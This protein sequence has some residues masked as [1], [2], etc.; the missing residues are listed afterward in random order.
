MDARQRVLRTAAAVTAALLSAGAVTCAG[1]RDLGP[2]AGQPGVKEFL[3]RVDEYIAVRNRAAKGIAPLTETDS[4]EKIAARE[5]AVAK[6]VITE[7]VG[8]QE[9]DIFAPARPFIL[10][11]VRDDWRRRSREERAGLMEEWPSIR[12]PRPNTVYPT[13]Q[14][15][16][17][18]PPALLLRLPTL[19]EDIE[20][21][22]V[23]RHLILRDV[24]CNVIVDVLADA[25]PAAARRG[26]S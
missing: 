9:G 25:L 11:V 10:E 13:T 7:R 18:A 17:T 23:G 3:A 12:R 26:D 14:P 20:Y 15:L 24:K 21:R 6:A 1:R 2:S 16:L 5:Q 22:L 8:A 4:P 19:P